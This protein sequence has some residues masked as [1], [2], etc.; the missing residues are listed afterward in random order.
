[1]SP[2]ELQT[3]K[4]A[5][6]VDGK[7]LEGKKLDC[8]K[9]PRTNEPLWNVPVAGSE[10]L[11]IA[12]TAA[13]NA[14]PIWSKKPVTERQSALLQLVDALREQKEFLATIV[15]KETG[16]SEI[17][18]EIVHEDDTV[19]IVQTHT[20]L[21]I[22]G[23]ICPWNFPLVL[24][25]AKVAAAI[26]TGNCIIVKPSPFTPY[27]ILKFAE[28][29]TKIVPA[30]VFQA[31]NGDNSLGASMTTH[32]GIQKISFTGSTK[33]GKKIMEAASGTLKRIT[34]ELGGN[35][36][37]I[38]CADVDVSKVA[39]EVANGCLF[40]AGQMCVATKRVYVHESIRE[41]FLQRFVEAAKVFTEQPTIAPPIFG[42]MQN[43]MQHAIVQGLIEDCKATGCNILVGQN[44]SPN[45]LFIEP[46]V[47]DNPPDDSRIVREEQF[48][49]TYL[50]SHLL[51][52][53]F[54]NTHVT[55]P[56]IPILSWKD[57]EEVITRAN[58]TDVGLGACVWSK[59]STR[60]LSIGR[61]L[62]AGS[63]WINSSEKPNPAAYFSGHKQSGIGGER[64]RQG[65]LSYCNTQSIHIYK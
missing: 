34:L 50:R 65:L 7:L 16:K 61:Q 21:G 25:V 60:A 44:Q 14:F 28:I 15:S 37:T 17:F 32:P 47:V 36:A 10:E 56:I 22:V 48:G 49:E 12:V 51:D 42:P 1:M 38:V 63:V 31:L 52:D 6:V 11:Q 33:T 64:G 26:V 35:D 19:Q 58:D 20:P 30:G 9:D 8:C 62:E 46:T 27:S 29:A 2:N 13:Q 4:F 24:A 43:Q 3:L 45:G 59:D 40:N 57:E 53:L 5:H 55:G 41:E 39:T 18:D 23:A 54:S